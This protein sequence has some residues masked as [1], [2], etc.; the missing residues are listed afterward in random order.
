M[1]ACKGFYSG[2]KLSSGFYDIMNNT[3]KGIEVKLM[4]KFII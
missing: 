3:T 4:Y 1:F 2:Q